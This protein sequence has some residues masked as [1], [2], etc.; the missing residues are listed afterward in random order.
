[1]AVPVS[2]HDVKYLGFVDCADMVAAV[3]AAPTLLAA[4]KKGLFGRLRQMFTAPRCDS[5]QTAASAARLR[6]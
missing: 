1:M 5:Q 4:P 3:L 6:A 2:V